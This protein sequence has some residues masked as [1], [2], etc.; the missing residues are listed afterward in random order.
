MNYKELKNLIFNELG[1]TREDIKEWV[2]EAV[3]DVALT[4]VK[5]TV[6]NDEFTIKDILYNACSKEVN[7]V[8]NPRTYSSNSID[9][10]VK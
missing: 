7:K 4:E 9:K 10:K 8:V 3:S 5:R 1:I 2:R 6:S